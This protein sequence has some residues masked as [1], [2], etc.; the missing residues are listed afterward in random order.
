M[1]FFTIGDFNENFVIREEIVCFY[2]ELP[3]YH[4]KS[5]VKQY[6]KPLMEKIKV[7]LKE[8]KSTDNDEDRAV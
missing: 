2:R 3:I 6:G 1:V 7:L 8:E 4:Y 5:Q